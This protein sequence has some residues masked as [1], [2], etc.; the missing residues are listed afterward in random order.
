MTKHL[1]TAL[2][3]SLVTLLALYAVQL[4]AAVPDAPARPAAANAFPI[5]R[6]D[7]SMPPPQA[8]FDMTPITPFETV[9][10]APYEP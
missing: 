10:G 6:Q 3:S 5:A 7:L 8:P 2:F 9:G 4:S 1:L